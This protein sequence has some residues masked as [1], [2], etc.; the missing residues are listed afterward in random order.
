MKMEMRTGHDDTLCYPLRGITIDP[1]RLVADLNAVERGQWA[2]QERYQRGTTNW[3]G[4][5]L[6]SVSG[7]ADDLRCA[8]RPTR[9]TPAGERCAY[10]SDELLP[11]F[12]APLLR[13]A[14]YR[15]DA[16]TRIGEH[17][18]YGQN[19]SMGYVRVHVPVVTNDGVVMYLD[20]RSYRFR[21]GE[22]WYFDASC[23]H[24]VEN[25]GADDRIHLIVDLV[26]TAALGALLKPITSRDRLRFAAHRLAYY[27]EVAATFAR[28]VRTREGRERIRGRLGQLLAPPAG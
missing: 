13:V 2:S 7:A 8:S 16:G 6:Y 26:P 23:R 17:C 28:F 11:Q 20:G 10:I 15:L 21:V 3:K 18:D 24:R 9:R 25:A 19:R 1:D 14:F 5:C 27:R 22:A 4:L 12:R